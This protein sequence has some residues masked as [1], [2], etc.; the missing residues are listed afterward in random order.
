MANIWDNLVEPVVPIC[1]LRCNEP[2][3]ISRDSGTEGHGPD[4]AHNLAVLQATG[5]RGTGNRNIELE[6]P[7]LASEADQ[8]AYLDCLRDLVSQGHMA[9]GLHFIDILCVLS[10]SYN[11]SLSAANGGAETAPPAA[12]IILNMFLERLAKPEVNL[13][14]KLPAQTWALL[15]SNSLASTGLFQ[16]VAERFAGHAA[17]KDIV[18]MAT[19][20]VSALIDRYDAEKADKES[21][22][23]KTVH[24]LCTNEALGP[25][26][27][28]VFVGR[29]LRTHRMGLFVHLLGKYQN[30]GMDNLGQIETAI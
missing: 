13:I 19:A 14:G 18:D 11:P 5:E 29:A 30:T 1:R 9:K 16:H 24:W 25:L 17:Q 23:V 4:D 22:V 12:F 15:C 27:V 6:Y 26:T 28:T 8:I 3:I 21:A 20:C 2:D 10:R 7:L